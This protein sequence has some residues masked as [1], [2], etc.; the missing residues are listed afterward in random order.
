VYIYILYTLYTSA[1]LCGR[2][3][4][5]SAGSEPARHTGETAGTGYYNG[6]KL[7]AA[8]QRVK[9]PRETAGL[10][11]NIIKEKNDE[12]NQKSRDTVAGFTACFH[13]SSMF[14]SV[15]ELGFDSIL[16]KETV[17]HNGFLHVRQ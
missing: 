9:P 3:A 14:V 10:K 1:P 5:Y 4:S 7:I 17:E 12:K 2:C 13:D 11:I 16:S 6:I 8:M 15:K